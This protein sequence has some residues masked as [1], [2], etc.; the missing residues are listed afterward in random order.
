MSL[1]GVPFLSGFYSKELIIEMSISTYKGP[2]RL[3]ILSYISVIFTALYS[4]N[5]VVSAMWKEEKG[6]LFSR[7]LR[8]ESS[9]SLVMP[10]FILCFLSIMSGYYVTFFSRYEIA[11]I[12][13]S[14]LKLIP[15][16][17]SIFGII[18]SLISAKF[19]VN[20]KK[21]KFFKIVIIN[22]FQ[23]S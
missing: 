2:F 21:H 20:Y 5:I 4:L 6:S 7:R 18:F 11:P 14:P 23:N 17:F 1:I 22:F 10:L 9:N 15:L 16:Y 8:T 12:I 19:M 3:A 13:S